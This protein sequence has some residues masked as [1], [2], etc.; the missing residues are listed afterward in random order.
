MK[1][2]IR[3]IFKLIYRLF[4]FI[5]GNTVGRLFYSSKYLKGKW[6]ASWH[7]EG[8]KWLFDD[9][10]G[11]KV[12]GRNRNIPWPVSPRMTVTTK[13]NISFHVDDINNF[14]GFGSYFQC[15]KGKISIGKGTYIAGNVGIITANHDP[16]DLDNHVDGKDVIIGEKCWIG[17]NC[18]V[19]PGVTLG[20]HTIV[21]AGAVV[22]KSFKDGYCVIAGNPAKKIKDIEI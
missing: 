3:N 19:L 4:I 21:G 22:T 8:W 15:F 17:M 18:V 9:F 11:Q 10:W 6:F 14:Q 2:F 5:F 1:K 12:C 20:D 16:S 13:D 7:G